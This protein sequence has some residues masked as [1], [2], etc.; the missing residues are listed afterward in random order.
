MSSRSF[1]DFNF[2]SNAQNQNC[3]LSSSDRSRCSQNCLKW[4][5]F[6]SFFYILMQ[7]QLWGTKVCMINKR[8][9]FC[10]VWLYFNSFIKKRLY[11]NSNYGIYSLT[12]SLS[13]RRSS[14]WGAH[15]S[16]LS[17]SHQS[18]LLSYRNSKQGPMLRP[19]DTCWPCGFISLVLVPPLFRA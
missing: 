1:W 18:T 11:F 7:H 10:F 19:L 13:S 16:V 17:Q 14:G 4:T 5:F 15:N 3:P 6:F 8:D 12:T 2:S 9:G